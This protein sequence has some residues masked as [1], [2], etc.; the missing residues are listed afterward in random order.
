MTRLVKLF[1]CL[2]VLVLLVSCATTIKM[3][4]TRPAEVN[5]AGAKKVAVMD[6]GIPP[7]NNRAWT[8]DELW[9]L[10]LAKILDIKTSRA[11]TLV[12]KLAQYTT[13]TMID[14]LANTNYFA[15]VNPGDISRAI[16]ASGKRNPNPIMIGQL[17]GAQAIIVGDI[18]TFVDETEQFNKTEKTKDKTTGKETQVTVLY[19]R[20]TLALKLT[21][22]AVN[23]TTGAIMATKTL[24]DSNQRE[25]RYADK[26]SL[27]SEEEV[28]RGMIDDMLPKIAKQIAPYKETVYRGLMKDEMKNPEMEKADEFVKNNVYDSA[29]RVYLDVWKRSKNPAAGV[30]AGIMYEVL[31]DLESALATVKEVVDATANKKAMG[32]YNRLLKEKKSQEELLKQL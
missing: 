1:I 17:V 7:E 29:L 2:S 21:Y 32:E 11:A 10:A 28:F 26:G 18:T 15:V 25:I 27:E 30:N 22:R 4:I 8:Y 19:V 6:F 31:G 9:A 20:R 3:E 24:E 5:M 13:E 14:T 23:T 12:E 16:I